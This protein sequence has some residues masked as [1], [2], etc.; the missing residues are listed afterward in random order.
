MSNFAGLPVKETCDLLNVL[1]TQHHLHMD[2]AQS[3]CDPCS[4]SHEGTDRRAAQVHWKFAFFLMRREPHVAVVECYS[5]VNAATISI[6]W[7]WLTASRS[8]C[9]A[10]SHPLRQPFS[11]VES[12]STVSFESVPM[13][14]SSCQ[15]GISK[16]AQLIQRYFLVVTLCPRCFFILQSKRE[17]S[18]SRPI[19]GA[20]P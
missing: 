13:Q 3:R 12:F 1:D 6:V 15:S 19:R 4:Y 20:T 9:L 18:S 7:F 8:L 16:E 14:T 17:Y 11:I 5:V 2:D 10:F